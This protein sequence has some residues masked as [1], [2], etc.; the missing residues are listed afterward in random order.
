MKT[1]GFVLLLLVATLAAPLEHVFAQTSVSLPPTGLSA[2]TSSASQINLSWTTPANTTGKTT[3]STSTD[4][5]NLG[6]AVSDFIHKRNELL[7]QQRDE[8]HKLNQECLD[9]VRSANATQRKQIKEECK[10]L[11]HD[12]KHKYQDLRKQFREEFKV[13][14]ETTKDALKDAKK[15]GL[16]DKSEIKSF[17]KEIKE[18]KR[19]AKKEN[20][21]F[22]HEIKEL[23]KEFK[24]ELKEL[25]K[26]S[27]LIIFFRICNCPQR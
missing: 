10:D 8:L 2:Q 3:N 4:R 11:R 18:F 24:K 6:Q 19:E 15:A 27:D 9:K 25:K 23:N 26:E 17:K 14:R 22:K 21:E 13:F 12:L 5:G 16:I 20:K 7:K 1:A